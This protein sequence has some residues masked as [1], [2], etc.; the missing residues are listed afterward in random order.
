[1]QRVGSFLI[2]CVVGASALLAVK[3]HDV[4]HLYLQMAKL[5]AEYNQMQEEN[6]VLKKDL[7]DKQRQVTRKI[8][9][10]EV[11]TNAPDEFTK[12][13]ITKYVKERLRPLLEKELSYFDSHP[14][15]VTGLVDGRIYRS[16]NQPYLIR[17][18]S[19]VIGETLH[20][21]VEGIKQTL[22]P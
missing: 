14:Q 10:I 22:S 8:R 3:G 9:K 20:I 2:G 18:Q 6:D 13:A 5:R 19:V 12:L 7:I 17:V 4:E 1:M 11:E 15:L 16:E 21:W